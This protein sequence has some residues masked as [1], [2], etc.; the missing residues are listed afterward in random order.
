M[1]AREWWGVLISSPLLGLLLGLAIVPPARAS[2]TP[3]GQPVLII[4]DLG[5][6]W[7]YGQRALALPGAV[8]Y[9]ILA[10]TPYGA[11]IARLASEEG[12]EVMLHQP[13]EA[14]E[15]GPLGSGSLDS[16]MSREEF[17][18]ILRAN[19]DALPQ[20]RGINN[21]MGS[22]L[23]GN[24]EMME[25]LM[26]EL[27]RRGG[28]YFVDSLTSQRSVGYEVARAL[29]IPA[30]RR[31]VFVDPDDSEASARTGLLAVERWARRRGA[32]IAI[33]HGRLLTLGLLAE[34]LPR[35]EAA[36]LRLVPV[37]ELLRA[38]PA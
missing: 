33:A 19:L 17:V 11:R 5:D 23:T 22:R 35:W 10:G 14:L 30:A 27:H 4:D 18:Q 8:P 32:V 31:Q 12:R 16:H 34:A 21:H 1:K 29:G 20:V 13:M 37:S 38:E 3:T 2:E 28:L 6:R 7:D 15:E 26:A 36:R 25:W 9:A 24:P